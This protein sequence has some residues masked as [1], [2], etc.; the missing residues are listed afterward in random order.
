MGTGDTILPL[1]GIWIYS[2]DPLV[3]NPV[4][5][6]NHQQ[7]PPSKQLYTGWNAIGYTDFNNASAN[8]S[9]TSVENQ[10]ATLIAYN[11]AAQSYEISIINNTPDSDAHSE[12][13]DMA[14]WK[15][16]WIFMT[17]DGLLSAISS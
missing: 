11:A 9:L 6:A 16:Y 13:R 8:A 1:E 7:V 2:A 14:P 3:I 10:W 5:D 12:K 17:G 15:G 4:F